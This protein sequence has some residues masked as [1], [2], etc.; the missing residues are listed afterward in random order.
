MSDREKPDKY[1]YCWNSLMK[2]TK[3]FFMFFRLFKS[4]CILTLMFRSCNLI[5]FIKLMKMFI[6]Y[7]V[8]LI[9]LRSVIIRKGQ[10][11]GCKKPASV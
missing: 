6:G 11:T 10:A 4:C 8:F 2:A 5:F 3:N 1:Y 7:L 9:S